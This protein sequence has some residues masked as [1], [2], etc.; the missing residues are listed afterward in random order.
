MSLSFLDL[1]NLAFISL[2]GKPLRSSLTAL[3]I[4]M[5]V[6][7][8]STPLQVRNISSTLLAKEMA[9]REAPHAII[10]PRPNPLTR[11][12][13]TLKMADLDFLR[14]RAKDLRAIST[15][16]QGA[17]EKIFFQ[18]REIQSESRG[19]SLEFL[20]TSGR[21]IIKGRFFSNSDFNNYRPVVIIDEFVAKELFATIDPIGQRIFFQN[22]PYFIIGVVQQRQ[23]FSR[24]E[25][26]G[27]ILMPI[28]TK[29][30][31]Q[32]R[33]NINNIS[34][35]PLDNR[36]LEAIG[37]QV[38]N[39]LIERYPGTDYYV[40]SNILDIQSRQRML[41]IVS[42]ILLVLGSIALAVGGVGI[43]NITIASVLERTQEIG[44]RRALGAT[45]SDV[46]YQFLLEA[47]LISL[48]GGT[49]AI[50][51]VHGITVMVSSNFNLPY[52]F[53]LPSAVTALSSALVVGV[54]ASFIP[55]LRASRL[56]P[57]K[58]LRSS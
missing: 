29:S 52:Q 49:I 18:D 43:T 13:P 35:R 6:L 25:P 4:F 2:R 24:Q 45:K 19:V 58:A 10:Y 44:L 39:L 14:V 22:R 30:I 15:S 50:A 3:G 48:F 42:T 21:R 41:T 47:A 1:L 37:K 12:M 57:V 38:K 53:S 27:L 16:I 7:A 54:G 26:R 46:L 56:D 55:A 9:S 34:V 5:G 23:N 28:T 36:E 31:L 33:L 40:G 32:G 17:T 20:Q 8:V 11:Q 51:T